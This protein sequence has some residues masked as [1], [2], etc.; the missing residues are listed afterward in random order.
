MGLMGFSR[1]GLVFRNGQACEV[2]VRAAHASIIEALPSVQEWTWFP[3]E[4][5]F[6]GT[7]E[8]FFERLIACTRACL[9]SDLAAKRDVVVVCRDLP[10]F[11]GC[12]I[13]LSQG[14]IT[15][16]FHLCNLDKQF[17]CHPG[18]SLQVETFEEWSVLPKFPG[19]K[20]G[21]GKAGENL[22]RRNM[23]YF[24]D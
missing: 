9:L 16:N 20:I 21:T 11:H 13:L 23:E 7:P 6:S 10:D 17:S 19:K 22:G 2:L 5:L 18:P 14:C 15:H 12:G 4:P 24:E 1:G 3:G 8:V